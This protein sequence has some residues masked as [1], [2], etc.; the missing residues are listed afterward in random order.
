MSSS[1]DA[2]P[3]K[4]RVRYEDTAASFASQFVVNASQEEV[5]INFSAG[6]ISDPNSGE[7]LLPIQSRVAM[8]PAGAVRLVNTLTKALKNVSDATKRT[9]TDAGEAGPTSTQ[10]N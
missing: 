8:S 4:V 9:V 7:N 1:D 6:Y 5:I 2:P 10:L 3:P